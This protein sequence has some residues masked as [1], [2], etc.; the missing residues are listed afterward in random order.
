MYFEPI[1]SFTAEDERN[2]FV[3]ELHLERDGVSH[4]V[5][6]ANV[7]DDVISLY[8]VECEKMLSEYDLRV[9]TI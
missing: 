8:T 9:N 5:D 2:A 1:V 6:R 4:V 3:E 7:Y